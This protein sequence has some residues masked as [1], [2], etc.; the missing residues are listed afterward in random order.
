MYSSFSSKSSKKSS[1]SGLTIYS[2]K[3]MYYSITFSEMN[4]VLISVTVQ[5]QQHARSSSLPDNLTVQYM[6]NMCVCACVCVC[7]CLY[8]RVCLSVCMRASAC[9]CV[10]VRAIVSPWKNT[11]A[12]QTYVHTW[13]HDIYVFRLLACHTLQVLLYSGAL[14]SKSEEGEML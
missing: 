9:M 5:L 10:R 1:T 14:T 6:Y 13:G 4:V 7:V 3:H 8:I 12:A 11:H 2:S